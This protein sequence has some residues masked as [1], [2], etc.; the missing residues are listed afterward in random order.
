MVAFR[1]GALRGESIDLTGAGERVPTAS[2]P[3][4]LT[5]N[6]GLLRAPAVPAEQQYQTDGVARAAT[7]LTPSDASQKFLGEALGLLDVDGVGS[8]FDEHH[9]CRRVRSEEAR[10]VVWSKGGAHCRVGA[11]HAHRACDRRV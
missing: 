11:Q 10:L 8:A 2:V 3:D 7:S 9:G 4:E 5:L 6:A 1:H